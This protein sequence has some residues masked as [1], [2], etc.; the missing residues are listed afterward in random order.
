MMAM[1]H[2]THDDFGGLQRDLPRVLDRRRALQVMGGVTLAG[3]LAACSSDGDGASTTQDPSPSGSSSAATS[4]TSPASVA[5]DTTTAGTAAAAGTPIPG[6]TAGPFPADGSNGPDVLGLGDVVRQD[7][8]NS[9]GELSGTADGIATDIQLILVDAA[10]GSPLAGRA[11]YAWHCTAEGAYSIYE[12]SDQNYLRGVQVSDS[13]GRL[14]FTTVFPGCYRGRWP[15]VHFEVYDA[16]D[17]IATAEPRVTSQLA[18]PQADCEVVYADSRYGSSASNLSVQS[19]ASDN[20]FS[21][22]WDQQ[23]ATVSGSNDAGYT[24]SLLVRV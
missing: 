9:I 16:P 21:D 11:V 13:A 12:V 22:G 10:T 7:I 5:T 14:T 19:L 23:L 1:E 2:D 15:H 4:G 18:L 8:R 6:E 20:I 17:G 24:V 3:L